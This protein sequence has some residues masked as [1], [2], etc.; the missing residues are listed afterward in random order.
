MIYRPTVQ[1]LWRN[2]SDIAEAARPYLQ[3]VTFEDRLGGNTSMLEMAF[4]RTPGTPLFNRG[5]KTKFKLS[6]GQVGGLTLDTGIMV[7]DRVD[8]SFMPNVITVRAMSYDYELGGRGKTDIAYQGS[9][10]RN[11]VL[12]QANFFDPPLLVDNNGANI[13]GEVVGAAST[14][15]GTDYRESAESRIALL[16]QLAQ[17]YGYAFQIRNDV[18]TFIAYESLEGRASVR[19][20]DLSEVEPGAEFDDNEG[21][22]IYRVYVEHNGTGFTNM[23]DNFSRS[24]DLVDLRSEGW[25]ANSVVSGR[26]AYGLI[27]ER[28]NNRRVGRLTLWGDGLLRAGDNITLNSTWWNWSGRYSIVTATHRLTPNQGWR[29]SLEIRGIND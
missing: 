14:D 12:T 17:K 10:L 11:I 25:Y 1:E 4:L 22:S 19:T 18:L 8:S 20:I 24:N 5:D 28:N 16:Q 13:M 2:A 23:I 9:T 3:S 21:S 6:G 27:K 7:V 29:T 26:R 15:G